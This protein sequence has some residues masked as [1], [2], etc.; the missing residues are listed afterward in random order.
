[1]SVALSL[2]AMLCDEPRYGFQLR[3]EFDR[4]TG[5]R[6]PLNVGQVY[7][8]LDRLERDG[9]VAR[10]TTTD[11]DGHVFYAATAAGR[12]RVERWLTAADDAPDPART[13]LAVKLAVA[14]TLPGT[15]VDTLLRAHRDAAMSRLRRLTRESAPGGV[16]SLSAQLIADSVLFA[17]ETEVRWLDHL[18]ERIRQARAAG[19]ELAVPFDTTLPRRGRPRTSATTTATAHTEE[20]P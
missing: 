8:T 7:K 12:D 14:L 13:D 6:W 1:M 16:D 20:T 4:R 11:A 2:L 5:D 15:D 9:L 10:S 19:V 18:A 17:A 3:A